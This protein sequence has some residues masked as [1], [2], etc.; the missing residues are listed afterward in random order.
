MMSPPLVA[1]AVR[2]PSDL[3]LRVERLELFQAEV[4]GRLLDFARELEDAN[5]AIRQQTAVNER[6][7]GV[8]HQI[9]DAIRPRERRR[10][11]RGC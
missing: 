1:D 10:K 11:R 9:R 5:Q 6:M 7:L 2:I 4:T 3:D 8:M